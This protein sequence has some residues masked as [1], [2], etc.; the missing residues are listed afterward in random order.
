MARVGQE[1]RL[2][3]VCGIRLL[4]GALQFRQRDAQA[5]LRQ[6][7]FRY[8]PGNRQYAWT[9]G[10]MKQGIAQLDPARPAIPES[11]FVLSHWRERPVF[12]TIVIARA[13]GA[14]A[15]ELRALVSRS[16]WRGADALEALGTL[17]ASFTEGFDAPD[18]VEARKLL[19]AHQSEP[20]P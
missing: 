5:F 20:R 15:F 19:E 9:L 10:D 11:N 12:E 4:L 6:L 14:R 18:W 17:H 8:I 13:S 3:P 1:G 7:S 16:R 2:R